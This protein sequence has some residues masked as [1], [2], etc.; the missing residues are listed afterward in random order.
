VQR[1]DRQRHPGIA[2][3]QK[4]FADAV[5]HHFSCAGEILRFDFAVAADGQAPDDQDQALRAQRNRFVDRAPVVVQ[6]RPPAVAIGRWK[7]SAAAIAAN[8]KSSVADARCGLLEASGRD[9]VAPRRNAADAV[10]GATVDD[11]RQRP[12]LPHRGGIEREQAR[13]R[14]AHVPGFMSPRANSSAWVVVRYLA[15]MLGTSQS[16]K[17]PSST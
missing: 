10:A 15:I 7:H 6:S 5:A 4:E 9:L 17:A 11:L 12:L 3:V 13:V 8:D 16:G 1:L 14:F 2:S